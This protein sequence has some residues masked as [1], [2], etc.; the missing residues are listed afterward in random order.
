[1]NER[2]VLTNAKKTP[3][4]RLTLGLDLL[5]FDGLLI[6]KVPTSCKIAI[7]LESHGNRQIK[8]P[9]YTMNIL[10][11]AHQPSDP[12]HG[13]RART[14]MPESARLSSLLAKESYLQALFVNMNHRSRTL[15]K[16]FQTICRVLS[17]SPEFL[18]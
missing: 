16:N 17:P 13:S 14:L 11:L 1:M 5:A 7:I 12:R 4:K 10:A 18:H 3:Y 8:K 2:N 9:C 6:R 15:I